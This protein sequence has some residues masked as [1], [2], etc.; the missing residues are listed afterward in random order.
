M[1]GKV[2]LPLRSL[3]PSLGIKPS[4]SDSRP[5]RYIRSSLYQPHS[6]AATDFGFRDLFGLRATK[7]L[8][9]DVSVSR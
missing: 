7:I 8:E 3:M 9:I 1:R 2:G 6:C 4:A 5:R